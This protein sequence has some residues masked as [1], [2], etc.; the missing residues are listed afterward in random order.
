MVCSKWKIAHLKNQWVGGFLAIRIA[1]GFL[2]QV[3]PTNLSAMQR[4][5]CDFIY[6]GDHPVHP[7]KVKDRDNSIFLHKECFVKKTGHEKNVTSCM[8]IPLRMGISKAFK[9][10]IFQTMGIVETRK[11]RHNN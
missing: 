10:G 4:R 8:Q 7:Q 3:E 11:L 1:V 2:N 6:F 5:L 9:R